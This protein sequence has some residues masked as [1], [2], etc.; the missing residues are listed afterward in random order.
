VT[1]SHNGA[2]PWSNHGVLPPL[3]VRF[4][5]FLFRRYLRVSPAVTSHLHPFN[6]SLSIF[7]N[8]AS[9]FGGKAVQISFDNDSSGIRLLEY[10]VHC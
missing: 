9:A 8:F 2:F 6:H 5:L 10:E 7:P 4:F 1:Q 3:A